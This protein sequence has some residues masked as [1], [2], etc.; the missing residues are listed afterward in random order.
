MIATAARADPSSRWAASLSRFFGVRAVLP[1]DAL[2]GTRQLRWLGLLLVAVQLPQTLH[3]PL[4]IS[5]LGLGLVALRLLLVQRAARRPDARSVLV[6]S[7]ALAL[8][9][10]TVALVIRQTYG[11]FLG[12]E[13]SIAF[14][15]VR[16]RH[17]VP[18][19]ARSPRAAL[20]IACL[21]AFS[22]T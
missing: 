5:L 14:L 21:G 8:F 2:L 20:L 17:Q 15:F 10:I 22:N 9:A 6:P 4:G 16:L 11:Y 3:L 13:P 1:G 19:G 12:R 18:R 7:W